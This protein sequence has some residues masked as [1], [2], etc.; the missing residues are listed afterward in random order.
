M[1]LG[2]EKRN[3]TMH[4]VWFTA[5]QGEAVGWEGVGPIVSLGTN[6][7][8]QAGLRE[9]KTKEGMGKH[10]GSRNEMVSKGKQK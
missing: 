5:V 9:G 7:Q 1:P 10:K 6:P 8:P 3:G 4:C 2:R